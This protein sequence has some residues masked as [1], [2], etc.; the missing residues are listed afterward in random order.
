MRRGVGAQEVDRHAV[1]AQRVT[2]A[3]PLAGERLEECRMRGVRGGDR[4]ELAVRGIVADAGG[5][6]GQLVEVVRI[7]VP[8][9]DRHATA[10][11]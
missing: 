6:R 4:Q 7:V 10:S 11:S 5:G 2:P 3:P 8:G 9:G 1:C